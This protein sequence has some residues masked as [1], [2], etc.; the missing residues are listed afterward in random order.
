LGRCFELVEEEE[1][2]DDGG[3]EGGGEAPFPPLA[4]KGWSLHPT[5]LWSVPTR[6]SSCFST[7]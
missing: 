7:L 2:E 3:G 5:T 6:S 1:E 4:L